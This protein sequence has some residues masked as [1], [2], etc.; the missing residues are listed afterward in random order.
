[1]FTM[2]IFGVTLLLACA[3]NVISTNS[4][5]TSDCLSAKQ[6][7]M[8]D[9]QCE[10]SYQLFMNCSHKEVMNPVY[11]AQCKEASRVL[12]QKGLMQCR[13]SRR[14]KK[15]EHC[16]T[17]YWT[18]HPGSAQGSLDSYDS[19][20][21]AEENDAKGAADYRRAVTLQSRTETGSNSKNACL[22]EANICS[23]YEKCDKHKSDY[24]GNCGN[25]FSSCSRHKCHYHLRQFFKKV[26]VEFTKRFLFCPCNQD[27]YCAER[28][29]QNIVPKCSFEEKHKRSCL[30][31]HDA[32]IND[33]L[34]KSRLLDYRKHCFLSDKTTE[35]CPAESHS[36]CIQS[37]MGMIGTVMTPNF[38]NNM[39]M[40]ISLWCTCEGS[41]NEEERC[42]DILAMFTSNKCLKRA[43][44]SE[45]NIDINTEPELTTPTERVNPPVLLEPEVPVLHATMIRSQNTASGV[46]S[47]S[48]A[49]TLLSP[50]LF[51][52]LLN[53]MLHM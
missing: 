36:P 17:I 11:S 19:P 1:M 53:I 43:L 26:P 4:T 44:S 22:R 40:D 6:L 2:G 41:A 27:S 42:K 39:S 9:P 14:M 16:V 33:N 49:L 47:P 37:Y 8:E 38:I 30:E 13:C 10:A 31:L 3:V 32:C 46:S 21:I 28:R 52:W 29:R 18:L 34:C 20:Y 51:L 15:E 5:E 50:A 25:P 7:C 12:S 35:G 24:A 45:L 23:S 48:L